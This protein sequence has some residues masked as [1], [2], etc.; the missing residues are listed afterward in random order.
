MKYL[1]IL[2]EMEHVVYVKLILM[3]VVTLDILKTLYLTLMDVDYKYPQNW[4]M[5]YM[6]F[7]KVNMEGGK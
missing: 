7:W 4:K 1:M 6:I 3:E 2:K 5:N